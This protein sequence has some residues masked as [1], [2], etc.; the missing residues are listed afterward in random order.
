MPEPVGAFRSAKV[1]L[2]YDWGKANWNELRKMLGSIDWWEFFSDNDLMNI[3]NMW[4]KFGFNSFEG[5]VAGG[6][7][8]LRKSPIEKSKPT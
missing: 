8:E 1:S 5:E 2:K 7:L 3:D 4:E 6:P